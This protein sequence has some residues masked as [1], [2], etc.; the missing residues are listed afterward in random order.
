MILRNNLLKTEAI[1]QL[2]LIP[3]EPTHHCLI[4]P[5]SAST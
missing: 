3:L 5:M 4:S 1:E 2:P